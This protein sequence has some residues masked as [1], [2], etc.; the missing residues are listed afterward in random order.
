M[1]SQSQRDMWPPVLRRCTQLVGN[2]AVLDVNCVLVGSLM[3]TLGRS[4]PCSAG[5]QAPPLEPD[6]AGARD[7]ALAAAPLLAHVGHAGRE[8]HWQ[9]GRQH[10]GARSLHLAS[11]AE[12]APALTCVVLYAPLDATATA[13][14]SG[15][16]LLAQWPGTERCHTLRSDVSTT[17]AGLTPLCPPLADI[18]PAAGA[19]NAPAAGGR[20]HGGGH[21]AGA[22]GDGPLPAAAA[23]HGLLQLH[24]HDVPAR[25]ALAAQ[26]V[27]VAVMS[28]PGVGFGACTAAKMFCRHSSKHH[29]QKQQGRV[30]S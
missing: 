4:T 6:A 16:I 2:H 8:A 11:T 5:G 25:S 18:Q 9:P 30:A 23:R 24:A 3:V 27:R 14:S 1:I 12:I 10:R 28:S 19:Q 21:T 7:A 29:Q 26:R 20:H 15:Q 22:T 13:L 17:Y